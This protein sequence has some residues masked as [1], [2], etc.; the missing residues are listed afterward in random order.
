MQYW[1]RALEITKAGETITYS[2]I[3]GDFWNTLTKLHSFPGRPSCSSFSKLRLAP[4]LFIHAILLARYW[5]WF[6]LESLHDCRMRGVQHT[7]EASAC[8]ASH[9]PTAGRKV[10]ILYVPSEQY[11]HVKLCWTHVHVQLTLAEF[12]TPTCWMFNPYMAKAKIREMCLF[13]PRRK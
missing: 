8:D 10:H 7:N 9:P 1:Y 6:H 3:H 13:W 4:G 11:V 2:H 5:S 12:M